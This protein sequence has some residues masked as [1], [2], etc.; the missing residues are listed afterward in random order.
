MPDPNE[1]RGLYGLLRNELQEQVLR[2]RQLM[3]GDVDEAAE[4]VLAPLGDRTEIEERIAAELAAETPLADPD[5]FLPAHRR[6]LQAVE[7]LELEGARSPRLPHLGILTGLLEY[8]IESVAGYIASN[9]AKDIVTTLHALYARR[10]VLCDPGSPE[11]MRLGRAHRE[12]A[13]VGEGYGSGGTLVRVLI[14]SAAVPVIGS[15]AGAGGALDFG[16]GLI[17]LVVAFV[18]A[19]GFACLAGVL[20]YGAAT[21][22]RRARLIMRGPLAALWEAVGHCGEPPEDDGPAF[23]ILVIVLCALV[24][25]VL[26]A[27]TAVALL[28]LF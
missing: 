9:Y 10:L 26:P 27:G 1:K 18:L 11:R 8:P 13:F 24:W 3:D 12:T 14:A 19:L 17:W 22:H 5:G 23:A 2:T 6:V 21:A 28:L 4:A 15:L 20:L 25:L 16:N 7:V